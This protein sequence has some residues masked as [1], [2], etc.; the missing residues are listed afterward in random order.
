MLATEKMF[1]CSFAFKQGITGTLIKHETSAVFVVEE[2]IKDFNLHIK[3]NS[4]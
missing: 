1:E 3:I 4:K 2:V